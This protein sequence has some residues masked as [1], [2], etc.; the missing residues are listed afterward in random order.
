M[1]PHGALRRDEDRQKIATRSMI[2]REGGAKQ[3][4]DEST[5]QIAMFPGKGRRA[6]DCVTQYREEELEI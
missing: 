5:Q 6:E 2:A 3:R 1:F 4:N